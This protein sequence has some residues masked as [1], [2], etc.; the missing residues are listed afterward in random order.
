MNNSLIIQTQHYP[1]LLDVNA[2]EALNDFLSKKNYSRVFVLMDENTYSNCYPILSSDSQKLSEAELLV[3]EPGEE[4][5]SIEI[6]SQLW[7]SLTKG[8]ADRHS[9][10]INL[11]GGLISDLG[12]FIASTFKRGMDFLNIPTSLLAMVDASIGGKTG[13]NFGNFKN[14]IG[15]FSTPENSVNRLSFFKYIAFRTNFIS[16]C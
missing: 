2:G 9:L 6:A 5:K 10:L 12:G 16:L 1:I 3:I 14:Q 13:I 7:G 8:K 4:N 15:L 11:G